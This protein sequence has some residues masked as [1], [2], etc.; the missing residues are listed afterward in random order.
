VSELRKQLPAGSQEEVL[1]DPEA[2]A[3]LMRD[4]HARHAVVTV[5][6]AA[7]LA[8][9]FVASPPI[10]VYFTSGAGSVSIDQ[11]P[12]WLHELAGHETA[13]IDGGRISHHKGPDV[14]GI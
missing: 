14:L 2:F 5:P 11:Q 10:V 8:A 9:A 1:D 6:G 12:P 7:A 3:T 4:L 13:P